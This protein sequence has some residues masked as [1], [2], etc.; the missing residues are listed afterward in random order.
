M[1]SLSC[2]YRERTK[3]S[4]ISVPCNLISCRVSSL[5][6]WSIIL[7]WE[8]QYL[9]CEPKWC[10]WNCLISQRFLL[11]QMKDIE[12][13]I[14]CNSC[15]NPGMTPWAVLLMIHV[16][17]KLRQDLLVHWISRGYRLSI[18]PQGGHSLKKHPPGSTVWGNLIP[19]AL[20]KCFLEKYP[21]HSM[22]RQGQMS[23][24]H[25]FWGSWTL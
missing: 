20:Q 4:Q 25:P 22:R 11:T 2:E 3:P 13:K 16:V 8:E 5:S 14:T 17:K 9:V 21:F 10:Q 12:V 7:W 19:I 24:T 6:V 1:N 18:K 23:K 15:H